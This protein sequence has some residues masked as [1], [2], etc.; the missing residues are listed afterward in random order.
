MQAWLGDAAWIAVEVGSG[1]GQGIDV[2]LT[3]LCFNDPQHS[4]AEPC[5]ALVF[6]GRDYYVYL[7]G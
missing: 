5:F 2:R 6:L 4:L 3:P 7:P 1:I